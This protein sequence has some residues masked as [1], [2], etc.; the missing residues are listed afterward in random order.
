MSSRSEGVRLPL[1]RHRRI[2]LKTELLMFSDKIL[3]IN[4]LKGAGVYSTPGVLDKSTNLFYSG[5]YHIWALSVIPKEFLLK[6]IFK[7]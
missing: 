6:V 3:I 4:I 2:I 7:N 1:R 5:E